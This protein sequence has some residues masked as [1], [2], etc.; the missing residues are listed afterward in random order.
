MP[1]YESKL[2]IS[3]DR[4]TSI[5]APMAGR[6]VNIYS[7][8][9]AH[10]K[11]E[12][13][14]FL[15]RA[16]LAYSHSIKT[17]VHSTSRSTNPY[18]FLHPFG[19]E[20]H[21]IFFGREK[22]IQE[23]KQI[24][25]DKRLT[26]LHARSGAGK[27]S[28]L[29]AGLGPCLINDLGILP[30]FAR[31]YN[32]PVSRVV[33]EIVKYAE[34]PIR[35]KLLPNVPLQAALRILA[36]RP[37]H[38]SGEKIVI[39]LDQFEE[40]F[41]KMDRQAQA[42][43]INAIANCIEDND[44][45]AHFIFAIRREYLGDLDEFRDRL[46]TILDNRYPLPPMVSE[47]IKTAI[48]CPVQCLDNTVSYEDKLLD[49]LIAALSRAD[50]DLTT[51]QIVC[52]RLYESAK[53]RKFTNITLD[54]YHSMGDIGGILSKYIDYAMETFS[55]DESKLARQVMMAL[56][57]SRGNRKIAD[58]KEI[59]RRI[60]EIS[61]AKVSLKK[62]VNGLVE[63][64]LLRI[65]ERGDKEHYELAHDHLAEEVFRWIDQEDLSYRRVKEIIEHKLDYYL[66]DGLLLSRAEL[67]FIDPYKR[68]LDLSAQEIV[69]I[70][71]SAMS[72]KHGVYFWI[73]KIIQLERLDL[74]EEGLKSQHETVRRAA[75]QALGR[76]GD[77]RAV[78]PLIQALVDVDE[79]VREAAAQALGRL[80]EISLE[81]LIQ[82]LVDV[83]ADVRRAAAQALG[84]LG[85]ARAVEPLIQAL[86]D[87]DADVRRA[88]AQALGRL[89]DARA[90]EPLIQALK[91]GTWRIRRAAA[92]ALGRLGDARAVKPLIQALEDEDVREAAAQAL[93]QLG[94]ARAVE[95]L[96][97]ALVDMHE[98]VRWAAAQALGRLG[99]ARAVEP[100]I[101]ALVDED[102]RW[103]A[104]QALGQLGDA[105]A[106]E[107]LKDLLVFEVNSEVHT[108]IETVLRMLEKG[109]YR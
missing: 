37:Y 26:V 100:L 95:P 12:L 52:T 83:D 67:L 35:P 85:D 43:A 50:A 86:E 72:E 107:P 102:V 108:A 62:V 64:R 78:E 59:Q 96:I 93:G 30:I 79:K 25:L 94:D 105:R 7:T 42:A 90:V 103:A 56:I 14:D 38:P 84:Q 9:S 51:L 63:R 31:T 17:L 99:D 10:D 11:E 5:N 46:R 19:I 97:Q 68:R 61:N 4:D 92:Q 91:D 57:D 36:Q 24:V 76:L 6:D 75:A 1:E 88:A 80:G 70:A 22:I 3:S 28:L 104:A 15:E 73:S 2:D 53:S 33:S 18:L 60:D 13:K 101:Q 89:G 8:S 77:A 41:T 81:P 48:T 54:L 27:S 32:D 40:I 47:D 39:V 45:P 23:L 34:D 71:R 74:L 65:L 29:N 16:A 20:H 69:L 49:E 66:H 87:M 55:S 82:A 44:L 106:V 98:D 58:G 21:H 109:K